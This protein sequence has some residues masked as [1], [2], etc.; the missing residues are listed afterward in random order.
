MLERF[1]T[2]RFGLESS[3]TELDR[4]R[5]D[6]ERLFDGLAG[7][8]SPWA[9]RSGVF[10]PVNVTQDHESYYIRAE[11]PGLKASDIEVTTD[12]NTLGI[13]GKRAVPRDAQVSYHR[14]ERLEGEFRRSVTLPGE[15]QAAKVDARYVNG[16]LTITLPKAEATKPKQITVKAS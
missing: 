7:S 5:R 12:R 3:F 13:A 10:P 1:W 16:V 8:G 15:F 14:C 9:G 4:M 11:L 2:P 6:M